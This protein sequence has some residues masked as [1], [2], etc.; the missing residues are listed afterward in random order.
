LPRAAVAAGRAA[1]RPRQHNGFGS[2]QRLAS[3]HAGK[4]C[5]WNGQIGAGGARGRGSDR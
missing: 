1:R 4:S 3:R 5:G 2:N